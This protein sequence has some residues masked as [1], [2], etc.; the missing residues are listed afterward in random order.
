MHF[1][2]GKILFLQKAGV[3]LTHEIQEALR[4]KSG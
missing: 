4:N 3:I 1:Y 2:V